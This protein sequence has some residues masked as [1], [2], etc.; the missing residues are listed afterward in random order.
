MKYVGSKNRLSK[1]LCPIIQSYINKNTRGYLEPFVGGANMIDKIDCKKKIGLDIHEE[2]IEL[3]KYVQNLDNPLPITISEE[4]YIKVRDNKENYPKWYVGLIGFC[5]TFG[6]KYFGGYARGFKEDKV[7]PRD[8]PSEAIRNI[9]SQRKN[10][11]GIT[12][13]CMNFLDIPKDKVK[14]YLIYC[15]PP[16]RGTTEYKTAKFPYD[17]FCQWCRDMSKDNTVLISEYWMPEDFICIWSKE[18]KTMLNSNKQAGDMGKVRIE[19]LYTY[20]IK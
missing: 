16:Y 18:H 20:N 6:S 7:T 1:E 5:G 10:L 2:L 15:D 17:E 3:L 14:N 8:I 4:E 9:Q 12:F 19:R 13:K 11:K